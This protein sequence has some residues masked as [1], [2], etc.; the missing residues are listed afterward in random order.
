MRIV[1]AVQASV[2]EGLSGDRFSG[3]PG[4]PRQVSL[5]QHEHLDGIAKLMGVCEVSPELVRR[6]IVISGINLTSL[7]GARFGLGD[8]VMEGT[9]ACPPCSRMEQALGPGG[10]NAMRGHG[11]IVARVVVSG[12]IR[13]GDAVKFLNLLE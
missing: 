12:I 5:I 10:Y 8:A 4:A 11:G 2:E 6:N 9:G 7:K 3:K 1:D 13:C